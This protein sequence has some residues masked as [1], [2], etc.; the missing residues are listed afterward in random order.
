MFELHSFAFARW[1]VLNKFLR[2]DQKYHILFLRQINSRKESEWKILFR[3]L[4]HSSDSDPVFLEKFSHINP[5]QLKAVLWII[6]L[7]VKL[8]GQST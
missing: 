8:L 7:G 2:G 3:N 4:F 1:K 5:G 6:S